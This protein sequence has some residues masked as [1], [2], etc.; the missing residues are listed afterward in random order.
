MDKSFSSIPD[1]D[2]VEELYTIKMEGL[3]TSAIP[4]L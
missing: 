2:V 1:N 4:G 3:N